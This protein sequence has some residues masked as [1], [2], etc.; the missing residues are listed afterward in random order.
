MQDTQNKTKLF[1]LIYHSKMVQYC[2]SMMRQ[3][4]EEVSF[5][6]CKNVCNVHN[7]LVN[8]GRFPILSKKKHNEFIAVLS[9]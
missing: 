5:C 1:Y 6:S 2:I 4:G 8:A 7:L 3:G 9:C